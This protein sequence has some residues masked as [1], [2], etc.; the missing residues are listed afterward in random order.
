MMNEGAAK[1]YVSL[2][3]INNRM[4]VA[5]F[6]TFIILSFYVLSF[7]ILCFIILSFYVLGLIGILTC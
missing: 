6:M 1:F 5:R 4:L 2:G 7:I 3:S